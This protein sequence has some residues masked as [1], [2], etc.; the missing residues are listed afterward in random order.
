[1]GE[2]HVDQISVQHLTKYV[3]IHFHSMS[4]SFKF[5]A[6]FPEIGL[7]GILKDTNL[8]VG[9]F[10]FHGTESDKFMKESQLELV[11]LHALKQ[12]HLKTLMV[13]IVKM[14]SH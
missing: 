5:Q 4:D 7:K 8:T 2:S 1:V 10:N 12:I 6:K 13:T 9:W 14:H 3:Q 11:V